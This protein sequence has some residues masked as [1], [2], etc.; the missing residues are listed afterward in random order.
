MSRENNTAGSH[1]VNMLRSATPTKPPVYPTS[2]KISGNS[3]LE[4][5]NIHDTSVRRF[6]LEEMR[7]VPV[8]GHRTAKKTGNGNGNGESFIFSGN[9]Y[10]TSSLLEELESMLIYVEGVT[11]S[12]AR[13]TRV[14]VA[15]DGVRSIPCSLTLRA[16]EGPRDG[17]AHYS[18][19]MDLHDSSNNLLNCFAQIDNHTSCFQGETLGDVEKK[20]NA[21][22]SDVNI[23]LDAIE[24]R[25][26]RHTVEDVREFFI[27][28]E[29]TIEECRRHVRDLLQAA[30]QIIAL[31]LLVRERDVTSVE[32]VVAKYKKESF[33]KNATLLSSSFFNWTEKRWFPAIE[34]WNR[35]VSTA[36]EQAETMEISLVIAE[37]KK[38]ALA[39]SSLIGEILH[40]GESLTDLIWEQLERPLTLLVGVSKKKQDCLEALRASIATADAKKLME[41]VCTFDELAAATGEVTS[42]ADRKLIKEAKRLLISLQQVENLDAALRLATQVGE[43]VTLFRTIHHANEIILNLGI[44]GD[45]VANKKIVSQCSAILT[46][47]GNIKGVSPAEFIAR[48]VDI[49]QLT[50]PHLPSQV[51]TKETTALY[52]AACQCF[53]NRIA[54]DLVRFDLEH[55]LKS[56]DVSQLGGARSVSGD[57]S[58]TVS[59][60]A[61]S[62]MIAQQSGHLSLVKS[63][64]LQE[65]RAALKRAGEVGL[66]CQL[67]QEG[68]AY[69]CSVEV[70]KLKIHFEAQLRVL[71][72]HNPENVTFEEI[73]KRVYDFCM[74]Q[75]A[76]LPRPVGKNLRLRYQDKDGDCISLLTQEDWDVFIA[77][78]APNGICGSKL[79][80]F[81]D[82]PVVPHKHVV[83]ELL[84]NSSFSADCSIRSIGSPVRKGA[85]PKAL[86]PPTQ[87]REDSAETPGVNNN[88]GVGAANPG[89][90]I[91]PGR[92]GKNQDSFLALSP[93]VS[94]LKGMA[95]DDSALH[96][97]DVRQEQSSAGT[98]STKT[99][100]AGKRQPV[101]TWPVQRSVVEKSFCSN[102]PERCKVQS[103]RLGV[104]AALQ[105]PKRQ[106]PVRNETRQEPQPLFKKTGVK[107]AFTKG[108]SLIQTVSSLCVVST[109]T[110]NSFSS[111]VRQSPQSDKK[112]STPFSSASEPLEMWPVKRWNEDD[113]QLELQTVAS[114]TSATSRPV[115][116][117]K[118]TKTVS[119]SV[120][121]KRQGW[122]PSLTSCSNSSSNTVKTTPTKVV[123][124]FAEK[125]QNI[126]GPTALDKK[127]EWDASMFMECGIST[128]T[129]ETDM[130]SVSFADHHNDQQL[131][132]PHVTS[133][134]KPSDVSLGAQA[135]TTTA[136]VPQMTKNVNGK[137]ELLKRLK[138]LREENQ[139][140]LKTAIIQRRPGK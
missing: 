120:A 54:Q 139:K 118:K 51:W 109:P 43:T 71:F 28:N 19:A 8:L 131:H 64:C 97:R 113:V 69:L 135:T 116:S 101:Q 94:R 30:Q 126:S 74:Q 23:A 31:R 68:K 80:L 102:T 140:A 98:D 63:G 91:C 75:S 130:M 92:A 60:A 38:E 83:D 78:E 12:L 1:D 58:S 41:N 61:H 121:E 9:L 53:T 93:T 15:P 112:A 67:V 127:R 44:A 110:K 7:D 2:P 46:E 4:K 138:Q 55:I 18:L 49:G 106:L 82:F 104:P 117:I 122:K 79:E 33:Q 29:Q 5:E 123:S 96:T 66:N 70:L 35:I 59:S 115:M 6:V 52:Q 99:S 20:V 11:A 119:K 21:A 40:P 89:E 90:F 42:A 124:S 47:M 50:V 14:P 45:V 134:I 137:T 39:Q 128:T 87:R 73:Y 81:C 105:S 72:I 108:D 107:N 84:E 16:G 114:A 125:A 22:A 57:D 136:A 24:Q 26:R 32:K 37:R 62:L 65:L 86:S 103:V 13:R 76:V 100:L 129:G 34:A 133:S 36:H 17:L 85:L 88:D 111:N 48:R 77:E 27:G 3:F 56:K 10:G 132:Q 95:S 25:Y